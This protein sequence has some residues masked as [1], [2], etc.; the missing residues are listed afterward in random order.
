MIPKSLIMQTTNEI[1]CR[2]ITHLGGMKEHD[3]RLVAR[4]GKETIHPLIALPFEVRSSRR[5]EKALGV[6]VQVRALHIK[7]EGVPVVNNRCLYVNR[8]TTFLLATA[9]ARCQDRACNCQ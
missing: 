9:R 7:I 1:Y 3:I 8:R 2:L 6:I 4:D 5:H